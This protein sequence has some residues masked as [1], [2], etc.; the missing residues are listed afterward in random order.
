MLIKGL[1]YCADCISLKVDFPMSVDGGKDIQSLKP[2]CSIYIHSLKPVSYTLYRGKDI[3][4]NMHTLKL[5]LT[6]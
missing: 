3:N 4:W 5:M 6:I 2:A 1:R